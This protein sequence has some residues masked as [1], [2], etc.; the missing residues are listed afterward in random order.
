MSGPIELDISG[1]RE[2]QEAQIKNILALRADMRYLN[3]RST[4]ISPKYIRLYYH[5]WSAW[6]GYGNPE[7]E[8]KYIYSLDTVKYRIMRAA[9]RRALLNN[10]YIWRQAN[11]LYIET[12]EG[13]CSFH[14]TKQ[15]GWYKHSYLR[16]FEKFPE[17]SDLSW[18]G[19]RNSD[20]VLRRVY[21]EKTAAQVAA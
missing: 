7:G 8:N 4:R 18:S 20:L 9:V 3:N 17:R 1:W 2:K 19:V 6:M 14:V 16:W 5:Y 21:G 15:G 10:W 13:Q 11:V 12:P